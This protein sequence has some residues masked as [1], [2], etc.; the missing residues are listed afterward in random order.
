M[1]RV[2]TGIPLSCFSL[3]FG[4]GPGLGGA[5]VPAVTGTEEPVSSAVV[6]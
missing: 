1:K 6:T 4:A 3:G 2:K 5:A